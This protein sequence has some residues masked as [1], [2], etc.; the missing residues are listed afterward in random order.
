MQT[1]QISVF[2]PG[3][4]DK[5]F[6]QSFLERQSPNADGIFSYQY[7]DDTSGTTH[8]LEVLFQTS[9]ANAD[10]VVFFNKIKQDVKFECFKDKIFSIQQEPYIKSDSTYHIPFKNEFFKQE[11]TYEATSKTFT[12]VEELLATKKAKYIPHHPMLYFMLD[13]H[14]SFNK[15]ESLP[16]PTKT[17]MLSCIASMDKAAFAGHLRR[18][19]F[20]RSFQDL[21]AQWRGG[22]LLATF[23]AMAS[24]LFLKRVRG[25]Y[26]INTPLRLKTHKH[27][28][29]LVKKSLIVSWAIV[30]L[31]TAVRQIF[32]TI[33][34]RKAL[35]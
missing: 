16:L 6:I 30:C 11:K 22:V 34:Q 3:E 13:S 4:Y 8:K 27:H 19:E 25:F 24:N 14:L 33:F 29:I 21:I 10:Y 1:Q 20:V 32:T 17:K 26:L 28:I 12:F 9:N 5:S 7:N 35:C 18:S 2:I 23:M 31:S 15:L